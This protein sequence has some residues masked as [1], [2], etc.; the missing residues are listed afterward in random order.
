MINYAVILSAGLG[1]RFLPYTKAV[2]KP[3]LP[4]IDTPTLEFIIKEA[5]ECNIQNII[6]VVGHNA[7][8]IKK[9]FTKNKYLDYDKISKDIKD[10]LCFSDNINLTF[11]TQHI[12]D[13][14][15][16]AILS[17]KDIVGKNDFL[18]MNGDELFFKYHP[19]DKCPSKQ[20]IDLF[21]MSDA[22][23]IGAQRVSKHDASRLGVIIGKKLDERTTQLTK[24]VEK[25]NEIDIVDP[26]VNL[27]RYVVK[28][29]IF[30]FLENV[31]PNKNGE[32]ALTDAL[33]DCAR[34]DNVLC[35][36]FVGKRYDI[37]NKFS[38]MQAFFDISM[39]DEQFGK[40]FES[41]VLKYIKDNNLQIT[42]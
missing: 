11:V 9:H 42:Q 40:D 24:I 10:K 17:A 22:H 6:V 26:L 29:N 33:V 39:N 31:K 23:I 30:K 15:A 14:T 34:Y 21:N 12:L 4:I 28:N 36:D 1:T 13:G 38:Y 5:I 25:P 32:Y 37:G 18:V 16:N 35:Y 8:V 27:G 20:L 19:Y 2:P 7:E 3:M 41:Y